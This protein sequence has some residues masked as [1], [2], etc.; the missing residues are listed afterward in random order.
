MGACF[1]IPWLCDVISSKRI[2]EKKQEA[3]DLIAEQSKLIIENFPLSNNQSQEWE[4]S[5]PSEGVF[6]SLAIFIHSIYL[7]GKNNDKEQLINQ[8]IISYLPLLLSLHNMVDNQ[9]NQTIIREYLQKHLDIYFPILNNIFYESNHRNPINER[10]Y[11]YK[12]YKA[13]IQYNQSFLER[14][15]TSTP[16]DGM[17]GAME[18]IGLSSNFST[19]QQELLNEEKACVHMAV[20]DDT[21][22]LQQMNYIFNITDIEGVKNRAKFIRDASVQF[23]QKCFQYRTKYN[24]A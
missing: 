20:E 16:Q 6:L 13:F 19:I 4:L 12:L 5:I 10:I 17:L 7:D 8:I 2:Q 24:I 3:L 14:K 15:L 22:K 18:F 1:F 23:T 11:K 9:Q 21:D